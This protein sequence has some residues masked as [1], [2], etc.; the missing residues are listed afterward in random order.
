MQIL[1]QQRQIR[2]ENESKSTSFSTNAAILLSLAATVT[3][4][5]QT[6]EEPIIVVEPNDS[7][8]LPHAIQKPEIVY[9]NNSRI[10]VE[11]TDRVIY[12]HKYPIGWREHDESET[13][14]EFR[15]RLFDSNIAPHEKAVLLDLWNELNGYDY[16]FVYTIKWLPNSILKVKFGT[17]TIYIDTSGSSFN[18]SYNGIDFYYPKDKIEN[19][20]I[21]FSHETT[22][23]NKEII[24]KLK[25]FY[26]I[27]RLA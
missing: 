26:E 19:E 9:Q 2:T 25:S 16:H 3:T 24:E 22:I 4:L 14:E 20:Q 21:W 7:A 17:Y 13:Y 5:L 27:T 10:K 6:K 8:K 12:F 18:F 1:K 11:L 23:F 15:K